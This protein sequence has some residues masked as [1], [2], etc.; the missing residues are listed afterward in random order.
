[1]TFL[2]F[3]SDPLN[4]ILRDSW[5]QRSQ[6]NF[7]HLGR[8]F[9]FITLRMCFF[10][11]WLFPPVFLFLYSMMRAAGV[12]E[13]ASRV[14]PLVNSWHFG[15]QDRWNDPPTK[16]RESGGAIFFLGCI[17]WWGLPYKPYGVY[18]PTLECSDEVSVPFL[19]GGQGFVATNHSK[20]TSTCTK[21][22]GV[23]EH[24]HEN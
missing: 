21:R 7:H 20:I 6:K 11:G 2:G 23:V 19:S 16:R 12:T 10:L 18:N 13:K 24:V 14:A 8:R 1:M 3:L 22:K 9:D 5:P 4:Q 17:I 15:D